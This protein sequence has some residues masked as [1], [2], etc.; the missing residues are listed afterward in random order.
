MELDSEDMEFEEMHVDDKGNEGNNNDED[1]W[2]IKA[3]LYY[4]KDEKDLDRR[5]IVG[6]YLEKLKRANLDYLEDVEDEVN[7]TGIKEYFPG[8]LEDKFDPKLAGRW[9][10]AREARSRMVELSEGE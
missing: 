5:Q 9:K 1:E 7:R 4:D 3:P 6:K 2:D 8:V 10:A